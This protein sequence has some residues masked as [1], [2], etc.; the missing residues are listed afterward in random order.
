MILRLFFSR[1][2][3]SHCIAVS[4]CKCCHF[5]CLDFS[6]GLCRRTYLHVD[7]VQFEAL[8]ASDCTFESKKNCLLLEY[9]HHL[10]IQT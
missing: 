3:L 9:L 10:S 5:I 7:A 1:C 8:L 4:E 6:R 2:H